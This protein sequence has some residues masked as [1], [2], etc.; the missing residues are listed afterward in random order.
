MI[1]LL[2]KNTNMKEKK[3][4][5]IIQEF[6]KKEKG[7]S[8]IKMLIPNN[9]QKNPVWLN[10]TLTPQ[11]T[12]IHG[13]L[14]RNTKVRVK[15]PVSRYVVIK[16]LNPTNKAFRSSKQELLNYRKNQTGI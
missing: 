8:K 3:S 12:Q 14:S 10:K 16:L 11:I 5:T 15:G 1:K 7:K 4:K 6:H 9:T 2:K 13:M